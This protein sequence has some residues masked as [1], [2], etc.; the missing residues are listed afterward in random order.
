MGG[1]GGVESST[2]WQYLSGTVGTHSA[3]DAWGTSIPA[4]WT[5]KGGARQPAQAAGVPP[6]Q[7]VTGPHPHDAALQQAPVSRIQQLSVVGWRE[8]CWQAARVLVV[9]GKCCRDLQHF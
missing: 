9:S 8:P 1:G 4:A 7:L 5:D 6:P 3:A 2:P